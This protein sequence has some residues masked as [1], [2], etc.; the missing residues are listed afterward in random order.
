MRYA[1]YAADTLRHAAADFFL[2]LM[3]LSPSLLRAS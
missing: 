1:K 3:P 2:L